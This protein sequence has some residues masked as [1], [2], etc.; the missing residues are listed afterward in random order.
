VYIGVDVIAYTVV[1]GCVV[2]DMYGVGVLVVVVVGCGSGVT[3]IIDYHGGVG[4]VVLWLMCTSMRN[5]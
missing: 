4:V 2:G 3:E 5:A 1:G